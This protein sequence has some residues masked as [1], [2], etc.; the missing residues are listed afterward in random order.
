MS[1][2]DKLR[3]EAYESYLKKTAGDKEKEKKLKEKYESNATLEEFTIYANSELELGCPDGWVACPN[4]SC[5][6]P[7]TACP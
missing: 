5:A 2:D 4:A 1:N 7:G 6:P 3:K